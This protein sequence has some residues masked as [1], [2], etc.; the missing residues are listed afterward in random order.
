MNQF[1]GVGVALITPFDKDENI[2]YNGR[3]AWKSWSIIAWRAVWTT[4]W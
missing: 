1:K 4:L 3:T 2:D